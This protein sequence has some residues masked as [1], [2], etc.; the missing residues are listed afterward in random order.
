MLFSPPCP[1]AYLVHGDGSLHSRRHSVHPGT[2]SQE[3]H[4]LVLLSDGVLGVDARHLHVTFLNRLRNNTQTCD[5]LFLWF[6]T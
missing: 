4:G 5:T 1:F 6:C 2:H 3:V